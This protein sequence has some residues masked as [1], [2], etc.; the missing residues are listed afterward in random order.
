MAPDPGWCFGP[1]RL[2]GP[3]GPLWQQG[4]GVPVQPKLLA[5][6]PGGGASL[7]SDAASPGGALLPFPRSSAASRRAS[8][9]AGST[10]R[11]VG[12]GPGQHASDALHHGRGQPGQDHPG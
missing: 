6:Y 11:Q 5:V 4:Q 2:V 9:R 7:T 10:P 12:P 3:Q 1:Y 8:D